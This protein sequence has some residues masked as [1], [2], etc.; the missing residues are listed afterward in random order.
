MLAAKTVDDV[1][2]IKTLTGIELRDYLSVRDVMVHRRVYVGPDASM[3]EAARLMTTR[4]IPSLP[5]LSDSGEV[6][7]MVGHRELLR[8]L[9]PTH[10]K[11]ITG[12]APSKSNGDLGAKDPFSITVREVMDRSV[13]CI[14]EDQTVREIATMMLSRNIDRFPVVRDGKLVG[15][16]TCGDMVRSLFGR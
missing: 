8:H 16:L 1:L 14:S 2:A 5:V 7:G 15:F 4:N 3:S 10:V 12:D 6:L 9:L 11:R 13:L